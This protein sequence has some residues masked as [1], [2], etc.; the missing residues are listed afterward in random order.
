MAARAAPCPNHQRRLL[1]ELA[2]PDSAQA[3]LQRI[4]FSGRSIRGPAIRGSS[5]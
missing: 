3:M 4:G 1:G 5:G 2:D